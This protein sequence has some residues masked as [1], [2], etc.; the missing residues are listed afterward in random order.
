MA[1]V[2]GG[3]VLEVMT[4]TANALSS[5]MLAAVAFF[6]IFSYIIKEKT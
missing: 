4:L 2:V 1:E 5:L 3:L 6:H